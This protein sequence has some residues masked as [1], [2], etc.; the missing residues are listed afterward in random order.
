[1]SLNLSNLLN[2]SK[3][4]VR[5]V[6]TDAKKSKISENIN[7]YSKKVSSDVVTQ[8]NTACVGFGLSTIYAY[9]LKQ[10]NKRIQKQLDVYI[11]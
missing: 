9:N 6:V 8:R 5:T 7:R 4:I 2:L 1:M 3:K 10:K 11:N